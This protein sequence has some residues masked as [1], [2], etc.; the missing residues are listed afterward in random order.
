MVNPLGMAQE[1]QTQGLQEV[2]NVARAAVEQEFQISERLDVKARGQ[3]MLAGQW[4]AVVQAV[5]AVAFAVRGADGWLLYLVGVV[6]LMGGGLL[7]CTFVRSSRVWKVREEPALHPEG[8]LDLKARAEADDAEAF[9][10]AIRHY[11]SLLLDRRQTNKKRWDALEGAESLWVWA[12]AIPLLQL[13]LA[14]AA[15]LFG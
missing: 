9:D 5:S 3:M 2:V 1:E 14:L 13:G 6:A 4:F 15:R 7:A 10:V 8:I 12:M 11:A